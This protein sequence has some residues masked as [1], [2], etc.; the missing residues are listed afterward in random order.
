MKKARVMLSAVAVFAVLATAF[1]FKAKSFE[2]HVL[3]TG[4][5]GGGVCT[6]KI[7][8]AT[9]TTTVPAGIEKVAA[10]TTSKTSLCLDE[11]T[12]AILD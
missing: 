7:E 3:Y 9:I 12:T 8:A 5:K 4:V 11:F 1:A 10:S 6:F 2:T